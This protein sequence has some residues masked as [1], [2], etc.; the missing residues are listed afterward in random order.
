MARQ[1]IIQ[2]ERDDI[3]RWFL[4][5]R[6]TVRETAKQFGYSHGTVHRILREAVDHGNSEVERLLEENWENRQVRGGLAFQR[7][8]RQNY[9]RT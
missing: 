6:S 7:L 4:N 2:K 3:T 8:R 1:F 9:A 5:K